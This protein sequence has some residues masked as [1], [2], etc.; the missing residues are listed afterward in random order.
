MRRSFLF[1]W[2]LAGELRAGW[3]QKI[4]SA[5]RCM[6]AHTQKANPLCWCNPL[7]QQFAR[8]QIISLYPWYFYF[9]ISHSP[10]CTLAQSIFSW[11]VDFSINASWCNYVQCCS[12]NS[13]TLIQIFDEICLVAEV[14]W[15]ICIAVKSN[16]HIDEYSWWTT[17]FLFLN[18]ILNYWKNQAFFPN[19]LHVTLMWKLNIGRLLIGSNQLRHSFHAN[20][21]HLNYGIRAKNST[22]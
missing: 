14:W 5:R 22:K 18:I 3:Y 7:L 9:Q 10:W 1:L 21:D 12:Q 15:V 16:L 8:S 13:F 2:L 6:H 4:I 19:C 11:H 17:F 20:W